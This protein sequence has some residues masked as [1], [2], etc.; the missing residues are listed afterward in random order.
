[1]CRGGVAE[2]EAPPPWWRHVSRRKP[3]ASDILARQGGAAHK[4]VT[5]HSPPSHVPEN[6]IPCESCGMILAERKVMQYGK[7]TS[8][9]ALKN[10][11]GGA[12]LMLH[13]APKVRHEPPISRVTVL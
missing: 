8:R 5:F 13:H 9:I 1:M 6:L 4:E 2:L 10:W 12:D 3:D 7:S 11:G